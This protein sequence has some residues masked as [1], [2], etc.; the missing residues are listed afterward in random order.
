M[1]DLP[2]RLPKR[3]EGLVCFLPEDPTIREVTALPV[4]SYG[5]AVMTS[6]E[7]LPHQLLQAL[8]DAIADPV[9]RVRLLERLDLILQEE[10][11][12]KETYI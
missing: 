12:K 7:I 8:R 10:P 3:L 5:D 2:E 1:T 11:D 6:D 9:R 4:H